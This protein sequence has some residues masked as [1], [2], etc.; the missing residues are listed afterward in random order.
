[1][2]SRLNRGSSNL[3]GILIIV[4]ILIVILTTPQSG[5]N[6]WGW[7]PGTTITSSS[8]TPTFVSRGGTYTGGSAT[9]NQSSGSG[10]IAIGTGNAAYSYQPYEEYITLQNNSRGSINITGWQLKNGK[11]ERPYN[12]GGSLQRFSADVALIPQAAKILS[13]SGASILQDVILE[14]DEQAIVTTGNF[15]NR[16]PYQ[17]TSFKEN[18]CT[19]YLEDLPDYA[20]NPSLSRNCPRPEREPGFQNLDVQCRR[21]VEN[22]SPCE[23]PTYGGKDSRGENCPD[24]IEGQLLHSSCAAFVKEHFS[25]KGCLAYHSGDQNFYGKT[26]R[27]FLGRGWE[28]WAD[29]YESIELFDRFGRLIN[30]QN[31]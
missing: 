20:F 16:Y 26:W 2:K 21:F 11:D 19:G 10:E 7:A 23:T 28:M 14:R 6:G 12:V 1:M 4:F 30:F 8:Y 31:Y 25:Y 17:I 27:I 22:L 3:T 15:G 5:E 18:M 24:C 29:E 13:P 9:Y